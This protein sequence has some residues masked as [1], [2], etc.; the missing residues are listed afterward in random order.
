MLGCNESNIIFPAAS[1]QTWATPEKKFTSTR[2]SNEEETN[3]LLQEV[4]TSRGETL[5][6]YTT[7][8][9]EAS[10]IADSST[11]GERTLA[12]RTCAIL[13][14]DRTED[15]EIFCTVPPTNPFTCTISECTQYTQ[16]IHTDHTH[17]THS[18]TR[19]HA[20]THTHT[21][22]YGD[23]VRRVLFELSCLDVWWLQLYLSEIGGKEPV[24]SQLSST[25]K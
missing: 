23:G 5:H 15:D 18:Y 10:C 9:R 11:S 7:S 25:W 19:T 22:A 12:R 21:L 8:S 20:H 16:Y 14:R 3:W 13:S 24:T 1:L 2:S 6:L 4:H 17:N